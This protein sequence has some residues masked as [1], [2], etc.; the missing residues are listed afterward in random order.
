LFSRVVKYAKGWV[1]DLL[2]ERVTKQRTTRYLEITGSAPSRSAPTYSVS[3]RLGSTR[4]APAIESTNGLLKA[5]AA[6]GR[7]AVKAV[8]DRRWV[9]IPGYKDIKVFKEMSKV[10]Q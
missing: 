2:Y 9:Y 4:S 6:G 5:I 1:E 3:S 8:I 10:I 7:T